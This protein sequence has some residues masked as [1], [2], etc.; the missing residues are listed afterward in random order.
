MKHTDVNTKANISDLTGLSMF[1][2]IQRTFTCQE[3]K[4]AQDKNM[5]AAKLK[6]ERLEMHNSPHSLVIS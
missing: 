3:G 1:A 2:V 6:V 4:Q 5:H